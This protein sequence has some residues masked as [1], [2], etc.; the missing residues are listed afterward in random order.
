RWAT[1]F[2]PSIEFVDPRTVGLG[3]VHGAEASLRAMRALAELTDDWAARIDDVLG[4]RS[5][6]L[7]VRRTD[8][9]TLRTGGGAYERQLLV[10]WVFGIDGLLTRWEQLDAERDAEALALFRFSLSASGIAGATVDI[11]A[12]EK[13]EIVLT[14]VDAQGHMQ[15]AEFFARDRL[16]DGVARL[17]ERYAD[18][19]PDGPARTRA[20]ATARSVAAMLGAFDPDRDD[21][22]LARFDE[23]T[24]GT[25]ATASITNAATRSWDRFR[26]AWE[27]RDWERL[28]AI[29][30]PGFRLID[31]RPMVRLDLDRERY[32]QGLRLI[33]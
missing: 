32:L 24:A 15:R 27:A 12:Y 19:L 18:L 23:L 9:G 29:Y 13:E 21:E 5:D 7:L 22:A 31:R 17:Y 14:E 20:A 8:S 10:L 3:S 6:A 11:G 28:A 30:A 1:A 2:A 4:L 33:F 25:P 26:E 16:G